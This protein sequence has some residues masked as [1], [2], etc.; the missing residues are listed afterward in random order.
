MCGR[1]NHSADAGMANIAPGLHEAGFYGMR[2]EGMYE[3]ENDTVF[4]DQ[5]Y[6][7]DDEFAFR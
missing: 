2:Y 4:L 5:K 6:S 3:E 7:E 1:G